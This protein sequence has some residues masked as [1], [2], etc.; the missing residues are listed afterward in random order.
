MGGIEQILSDVGEEGRVLMETESKAILEQ[1]GIPTVPCEVATSREE[2][3]SLAR[4]SGF[5]VVLKI[6][7]PD[8]IHKAQ[9]GGV[10]VNL[11]T[12]EDVG[13]A[14]D[15][16]MESARRNSP[17]ARILGA[18]VQQMVSGM[19][20]AVG[21]TND[22][23]FGH[24][25]M[26]GMGGVGIEILRDVAFRLIPISASDADEMLRDIKGYPVLGGYRGQGVDLDSLRSVLLKVSD[27]I[28]AHPEIEEM[29]LNPV[30]V[31][32][33]GSVVADARVMLAPN[34]G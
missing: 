22:P 11:A 16:I 27:L 2:A 4:S 5:P 20:V 13:L 21:V 7:S 28:M 26:F 1:W 24:V 18:T 30:I 9:A 15:R 29:D 3:S 17:S 8:I 33:S 12:D 10:R 31:S 19:E 34:S 6:L 32:P 25:L 23:Q 14:F